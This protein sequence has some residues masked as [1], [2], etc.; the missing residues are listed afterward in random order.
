MTKVWSFADLKKSFQKNYTLFFFQLLCFRLV[1]VNFLTNALKIC[2]WVCYYYRFEISFSVE[3]LPGILWYFNLIFVASYSTTCFS[4]FTLLLPVGFKGRLF[5]LLKKNRLIFSMILMLKESR[6]LYYF[7]LTWVDP[8]KSVLS[9]IW[10][11]T[12]MMTNASYEKPCSYL[13]R[14]LL[15]RK[16]CKCILIF[17][18]VNKAI[19]I[20]HE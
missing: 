11:V 20:E 2:V 1:F 15:Q 10:T 16:G 3:L 7:S 19:F 12:R 9:K 6:D 13:C 8:G 5:F 4:I 18:H 17:L 14:K